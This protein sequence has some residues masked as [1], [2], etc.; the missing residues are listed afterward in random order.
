MSFRGVYINP[1]QIEAI[2]CCLS[3]F[4]HLSCNAKVAVTLRLNLENKAMGPSARFDSAIA[5]LQLKQKFSVTRTGLNT[6][7]NCLYCRFLVERKTLMIEVKFLYQ[8][9]ILITLLLL[10]R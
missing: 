5:L 6:L 1:T 10:N 2:K 9:S 4:S 7:K 3:D 8:C